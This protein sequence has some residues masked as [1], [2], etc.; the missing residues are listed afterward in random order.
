MSEQGGCLCDS[1]DAVGGGGG[2]QG[3]AGGGGAEGR[4]EV[5]AAQRCSIGSPDMPPP[6]QGG[7]FMGQGGGRTWNMKNRSPE[8]A[9]SPRPTTCAPASALLERTRLA[10]GSQSHTGLIH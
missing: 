7:L 9:A 4:P 6:E 3:L 5:L 8:M 2:R 10:A 1:R